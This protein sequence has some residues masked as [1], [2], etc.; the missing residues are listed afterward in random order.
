MKNKQN[1]IIAG[2]SALVLILIVLLAYNLGKNAGL[3]S[4]NTANTNTTGES[5]TNN[6]GSESTQPTQAP[7]GDA[8]SQADNSQAGD[9]SAGD[10][11]ATDNQSGNNQTGETPDGTIQPGSNSGNSQSGGN[12]NDNNSGSDN[13][14]DNTNND[15]QSGN[16]SNE[17]STNN[18]PS[19]N[20]SQTTD[21]PTLDL[22]ADAFTLTI[23]NSDSWGENP[24]YY[25]MN[26]WLKNNTDEDVYGWIIRINVGDGAVVDSSW[27]AICSIENGILTMTNEDHNKKVPAG[28][29]IDFGGIMYNITGDLSYTVEALSK[30]DP[31]QANNQGNGQ[32]IASLDVPAPTTDDWL[33]VEGNKIVDSEGKQVWLTGVN[34]FGYNTGTNLFD[35]IWNSDLNTSIQ[36]IA[37]HG[38]N[39]I[40]IPMSAELILQW[41]N[42]EYPTANYNHATNY[43]LENMNS[44]EI[45]DYVIGQC[46]ANGLKLMIDIH[47]AKTDASGHNYNMWYRDDITT[48][49]YQEALVWMAERYAKDDTIIAYDLKNEPHGKPS[50]TDKA[51]WNDSTSKNNWKYVAEQTALKIL[52]KNPN[53]LIMVEG[54][55]IYPVDIQ[56]NGDYSST[57]DSDYYFN[58]WGGN[59]RGV[60]DY[61][62]DLG[63]YQDQLVYSPHDYGPTVYQ[64][65]WFYDGYNYN[66]LYEDCWKDNW[67][68]IYEDGTAPLLIGEW[69]GFMTEPNLTWMTHMR[70]LISKYHLHHTFWC[71][72]ANSGDT[73]GLVLDDFTTWDEEKYA[74][75]KEVLWQENGKFVGLDHQI[76]LGTAGNGIT[77]S[78]AKGLK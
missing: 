16:N 52:E 35:G 9:K 37:D 74:F 70:T 11:Q 68:Y 58:W 71:F 32:A 55:E 61:P 41:K 43:Y 14:S 36:G 66:S 49:K 26:M 22:P 7:S 53:V 63:K 21:Q 69:G 6:S 40:R 18:S 75:V 34:W 50:E 30:Q 77:L 45:F 54:T 64:Q 48:E 57:K 20:G 78:E 29:T 33:H 5:Q 8:G 56:A 2:L 67:M 19:G 4:A 25:R 10:G 15:S 12:Q 60:A 72:N 23:D 31:N 3:Q 1:L 62:I 27:R 42:G 46:R 28:G 38:F 44:L 47:T 76:P 24:K 65:P 73:G 13:Q 17:G 39:L 51:I 59:L